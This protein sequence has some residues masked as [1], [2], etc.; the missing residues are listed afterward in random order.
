MYCRYG[1][2][3]Q[4]ADIRGRGTDA[5]NSSGD[6]QIFGATTDAHNDNT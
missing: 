3:T 6:G 1:T 4:E 2:W 5:G